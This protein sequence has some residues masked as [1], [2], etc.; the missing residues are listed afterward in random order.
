MK[1]IRIA[2]VG[3]VFTM[4][5]GWSH[6]AGL[7]SNLTQKGERIYEVKDGVIQYNK[8]SFKFQGE[9]LYEMQPGTNT[10]RY[11]K[12]SFINKDGR[13]YEMEPGTN[14]IRYDKPSY[15]MK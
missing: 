3:V 7:P 12:P 9:R 5:T 11:D 2:F 8:P 10:I 1:T 13:I 6:A 14:M 4:A 15:E